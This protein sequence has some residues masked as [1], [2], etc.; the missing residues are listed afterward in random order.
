MQS[1]SVIFRITLHG[2]PAAKTSL[3]KERVTTLPAPITV[4]SPMVTPP[5]IIT[6]EAIQQSEPIFISLANS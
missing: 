1:S 5:Q 6:L 4:R 3:G 2:L